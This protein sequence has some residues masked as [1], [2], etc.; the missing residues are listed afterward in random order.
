MVLVPS[1]IKRRVTARVAECI[2]IANRHYGRNLPMPTIEYGLRGTTA[3]RAW[4]EEN[5]MKLNSMLLVENEDD[6]ITRTIGHETAHIIDKAVNGRQYKTNRNGRRVNDS[7]GESWKAVMVLLGQ[8]PSRC[9][10]FDTTNSKVKKAPR[11]KFV[12]TCDCAGATTMSLGKKRHARQ[13]AT[14]TFWIRRIT[15]FNHLLFG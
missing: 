12:W 13:L 15:R 6:F 8:N 11:D 14:P 5:R 1:R 10:S 2:E 3:G 9:H 7:H 4:G